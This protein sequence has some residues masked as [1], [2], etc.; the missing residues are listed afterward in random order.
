MR[1]KVFGLSTSKAVLLLGLVLILVIAV[2]GAIAV[3]MLRAQAIDEWR[4]QM[5]NYSLVLASHTTQTLLRQ[6]SCST[7][8]HSAFSLPA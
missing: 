1:N 4:G 2:G 7:G 6:T 3:W 5:R 8:C